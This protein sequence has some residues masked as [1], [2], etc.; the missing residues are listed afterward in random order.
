MG[1]EKKP[2]AYDAWENLAYAYAEQ[3]ETKP[4][5]AYLEKPATLS[6][7]PD[8]VGKWVLDVGCGPGSKAHWLVEHGAKVTAIDA[9]PK[10]VEYARKRLGIAVDVKLH[11]IEKPLT[12]LDDSSIDS[13]S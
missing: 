4:H 12:F 8:L 6:L 5:N 2:L 1:P 3:V 10:M 11:D 7:L 9:S 13:S